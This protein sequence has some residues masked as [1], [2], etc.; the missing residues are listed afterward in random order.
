MT[1]AHCSSTLVLDCS[2]WL[3][4]FS[5]RLPFSLWVSVDCR[6][7]WQIASSHMRL[8]TTTQAAWLTREARTATTP[9]AKWNPLFLEFP[10]VNDC[11]Q[12]SQFSFF[13]H[14]TLCLS[15]FLSVHTMDTFIWQF[16]C[17]YWCCYR[18]TESPLS[19]HYL[20][21]SLSIF[22]KKFKVD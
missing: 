17:Q 1:S 18:K 22:R 2:Y 11:L 14:S 10:L 12:V 21:M 15:L 5:S 19:K 8:C 7:K 6:A 9:P 13:Y 3:L 20:L 4:F 16:D